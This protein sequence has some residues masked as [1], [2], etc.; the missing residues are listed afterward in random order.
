MNQVNN[1]DRKRLAF[2]V[3]MLVLGAICIL[4]YLSVTGN[5]NQVFTDIVIEHTAGDGSNKSAEKNLFY[6]FSIG[7]ILIYGFFFLANKWWRSDDTIAR[8]NS[9]KCVFVALGV[10][11]GAG[12]LFYKSFN[13]IVAVALALSVIVYLKD[14]EMIIPALS[15]FFISIYSICGVYRLLALIGLDKGLSLKPV[16]VVA[17][18]FSLLLEL[19]SKESQSILRGILITQILVP[20]TLLV[21]LSNRYVYQGNIVKINIP[22]RV[23]LLIYAL[24]ILFLGEALLRIRTKWNNSNNISDVLSF[25]TC[26]S[27]MSFNRFSGTGAIMPYDLH[28]FYENVIG[29][30]QIFELGQKPF[31]EYIPVSGMYSVLHGAVFK[32]LG[33]GLA[34]NY[35]LAAN[36]FYLAIICL[37]VFLLRRQFK[38]E[39]VLFISLMFLVTDYN[40]IALI[41]PNIL[42]LSWPKLIENKNLWLKAWFLSSLV[43]GLYYPVFGAAVCLGFLPLGAYQIYKYAKSGELLKDVKTIKFWGWW[44]VCFIPAIASIGLLL[45]TLK[46]MLAMGSQTIF[47]D[48]IT[49]FGQVVPESFL[50]YIQ[51]EP[52]R[53]ITYYICSFLVLIS[54]IWLA[55]A[56]F[57]KLGRVSISKKGIEIGNSLAACLSLSVVFILLV[58]FSYTVVRMD[59]RDIYARSD[60]VVKAAFVVLLILISRYAN[61]N[62]N[63]IIVFAFSIFIISLDSSIGIYSIESNPSEGYMTVASGNKLESAYTVPEKYVYVNE[64][65]PRLG[66]GFVDEESYAY[67]S[68]TNEYM[69][70]LDREQT[71]LGMVDSFGLYYLCDI[72]GDSVME[73]LNTIKGYGAVEETVEN[74]RANNTIVGLNV[75]PLKNYYFY[76]WL[77]TSGE[78]VFNKEARLFFPNEG[79]LPK[80]DVLLNNKNIDLPLDY[81]AE[82]IGKIAGSFGSSIESLLPIFT[83]NN[84]K[85]EI[86][87]KDNLLN[88]VFENEINGDDADFLYLE[89]DVDENNYKYALYDSHEPVIQDESKIGLTKSLLRKEYN[90][91]MQVTVFWLDDEGNERSQTCDMDEG[92][93]LLPLGACRG[94]LLNHISYISISV[95]Q[96]DESIAP[97][98]LNSIKLF[99]CRE[100]Q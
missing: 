6:L 58:A 35:F 75:N 36:I 29:Y 67:I 89:F 2:F 79:Q 42:L 93:L 87:A 28:H 100:V 33:H 97:M 32:W 71:Y 72:K 80:D 43:H 56:L 4:G 84:T 63:T 77:L 60:G 73:V 20:F 59:Y 24:V 34:S 69:N 48:G 11:L 21:Y 95:T 22:G 10:V 55:F 91:G 25:G 53:L 39:W 65:N 83:E 30:S 68:R 7:G 9:S 18:I 51:N 16:V 44:I 14:K 92:K 88:I 99:K 50:P 47:A 70:T 8:L 96:D 54:I 98:N 26:V 82:D 12:L 38:G 15:F 74:I 85:Y 49:R 27:I 78:Y 3:A 86:E 46:H 17:F 62:R 41:V 81:Q 45:G 23:Q 5:I 57:M 19:A 52:I 64:N 94:W 66:E 76:H 40:R 90:S 37:I 61:R 1:S 13:L 31:K